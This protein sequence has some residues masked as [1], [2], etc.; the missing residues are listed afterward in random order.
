[1]ALLEAMAWELPAITTPVGGIPE[2]IISRKNGILVA[3][4]DIPALAAAI[5]DL[6]KQGDFRTQLGI[7]ARASVLDL[8]INHYRKNVR[9]VYKGILTQS[10]RTKE[11]NFG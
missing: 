11:P 1:M 8:D 3:P 10:R 6:V 2:V 7:Q 4:G 9:E 5:D